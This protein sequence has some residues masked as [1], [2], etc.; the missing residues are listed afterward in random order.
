M[1]RIKK[2]I[3]DFF[4]ALGFSIRSTPSLNRT[5]A[6]ARSGTLLELL[7][8]STA[9]ND[10]T[11]GESLGIVTKAKS[12]LGQD[13]LALAQVGIKQP[14]FFVE[15]GSTNGLDL[16]N[17]YLLEKNFGWKGILCEPAKEWHE[18][19]RLNRSCAIDTRCVYSSTGQNIQFSET[20]IGELSTISSYMKSDANRLIRKKSATYEVETVTLE[21]LLS[22]H[23]A[24][25]YIDFLS[26]DTEGSEYE[27]LNAF[28]FSRYSF[29]LICVEHNFTNNREK[30][31]ELLT[32]NG[33][34]QVLNEYS[35]FDDWYVG[36]KR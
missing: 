14:G 20:S 18:E 22:S 23:N 7:A 12:Q 27:I 5:E 9:T 25:S 30:I 13:V 36:A 26:I 8:S 19:L 21:D 17:T 15:F 35:A 33:Y 24:P 2:L 4:L 3:S 31:R 28:D 32:A 16:S 29:G 1:A 34:S 6:L 11:L 10:L